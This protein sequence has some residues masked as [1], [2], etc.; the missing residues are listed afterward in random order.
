MKKTLLVG[1]LVLALLAGA[2]LSQAQNVGKTEKEVAALERQWLKAQKDSNPDL[3]A[4]L[5]A[6]GFANTSTDGTVTNKPDTLALVKA[7]KFESAEYTDVRVTV[8]GSTA[9]A[10]GVFSGKGTDT[11]G[12]TVT[13]KERWTD[14]WVKMPSGKWQCVASHASPMKP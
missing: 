5:L 9:I 1:S 11:S 6:D 13:V 3:L 4:P 10:T 2:S 8:F 12:K 14:T 7:S